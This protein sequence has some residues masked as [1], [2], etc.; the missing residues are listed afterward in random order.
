MVLFENAIDQ[1]NLLIEFPIIHMRH[2]LEHAQNCHRSKV[3]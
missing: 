1:K 3:I 2:N